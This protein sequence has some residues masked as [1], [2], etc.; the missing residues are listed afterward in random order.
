MQQNFSGQN[1]RERS[2]KNLDLTGADFSYADIRST[3]FTDAIL[4][5]ANFCHAQAGLQ[6]Q[7]K[8]WERF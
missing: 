5:G 4:T 8:H 6:R 3:D 2:F 7:P 1:L